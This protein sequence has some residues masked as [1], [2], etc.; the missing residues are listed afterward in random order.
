MAEQKGVG[1]EVMESETEGVVLLRSFF[2]SFLEVS[3]GFMGM[4]TQTMLYRT[5][6]I[7]GE[8]F[9]EMEPEELK[10]AFRDLG[11]GLDVEQAGLQAIFVVENS[12]EAKMNGSS[13]EPSCH[14]LR[15]FFTSYVRCRTR[16]PYLRGEEVECE[17]AGGDVCRFVVSP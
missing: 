12:I 5:G 4:A 13:H 16:N 17:A 15:G 6:E 1:R 9:S 7:V 14:M 11:M 10:R 3:C 2:A 8:A